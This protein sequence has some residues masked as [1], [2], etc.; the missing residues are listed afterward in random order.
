MIYSLS[1]L[2]SQSLTPLVCLQIATPHT[3]SRTQHGKKTKDKNTSKVLEFPIPWVHLL[4]DQYLE[5]TISLECYTSL[6]TTMA[7]SPFLDNK[8]RWRSHYVVMRC[9]RSSAS[10]PSPFICT[11]NFCFWTSLFHLRFNWLFI[12]LLCYRHSGPVV[13]ERPSPDQLIRLPISQTNTLKDVV[14]MIRNV[15]AKNKATLFT[16]CNCTT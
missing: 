4:H 1:L 12:A 7:K 10:H 3:Y 14:Y 8:W 13:N 2:L 6:I 9:Y 5:F 15:F 16:G 11:C